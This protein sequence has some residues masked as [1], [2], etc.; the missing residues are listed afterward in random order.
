M[1]F[2]ALGPLTVVADGVEL[3]LGGARPRAILAMLLLNLNQV[4]PIARIVDEVWAEAAPQTVRDQVHANISRLRHL[5]R[6]PK[7]EIRTHEAGYVLRSDLAEFDVAVFDHHVRDGQRLL[8]DGDPAAAAGR[9]DAAL[10]LWRGTPFGGVD[11]RVTAPEV[12]R[13]CELRLGAVR[14]RTDAYLSLGRGP[15]TLAEL[16]AAI[17]EHPLHEDLRRMLMLAQYQAGGRAEALAAYRDGCR[18]LREELGLDPGPELVALHDAILRDD[19]ALHGVRRRPVAIV[20]PSPVLTGTPAQLPPADGYFTGRARQ[21]GWL[22]DLVPKS[23][24][25]EQ[26]RPPADAPQRSA[27]EPGIALISGPAGTGKTALAV[28]WAHRVRSGFPDGQLY[29]DLEEEGWTPAE[30]LARLLHDLGV[31]VRHQPEEDRAKKRV[32]RTV[33]ADRACLVLLENPPSSQHVLTLIPASTRSTVIV[34]S[35]TWLAA[36]ATHHSVRSLHLDYLDHE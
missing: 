12:A 1:I 5:L 24:T 27:G 7:A 35:R 30:A 17:A 4:V 22:D 19:P 33:T 32:Y 34:T 9:L 6:Q 10:A 14:A 8:A 2:L 29:L 31:P 21:L 11:Q 13:L 25:R 16:A 18:I 26:G 36:L 3:S 28:Q 23:R 15:E 20:A